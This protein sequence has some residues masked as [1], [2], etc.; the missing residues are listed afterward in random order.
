MPSIVMYSPF[1]LYPLLTIAG[2][3]QH[4]FDWV[5]SVD[6][7]LN[8]LSGLVI[9]DRG[10]IGNVLSVERIVGKRLGTNNVGHKVNGCRR[11]VSE[12]EQLMFCWGNALP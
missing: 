4:A 3:L 11:C 8:F 5:D 2:R 6:I 12:R 9:C 1:S 10:P 7:M